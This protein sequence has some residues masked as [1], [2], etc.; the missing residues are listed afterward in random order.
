MPIIQ[1]NQSF[2]DIFG[3][4]TSFLK[5][6]AGDLQTARISIRESIS[7]NSALGESIQNNFTLDLMTWL[8]G[9]WEAEG[10]RVGDSIGIITYI[11][12][13]G[14]VLASTTTNVVYINGDEME[15]GLALSSW[16]DESSGEAVIIFNN[17]NREQMTLDFNMVVNG[18]AGSQY[19]LIDGEVS[20]FTFDL[21]GGAGATGVQIGNKSGAYDVSAQML[22]NSTSGIFKNYDLVINFQQSGL[23]D[24]NLFSFDNCLKLYAKMSWSS[25][26]GEPFGQTESIFNDDADTGWF[27]E[28]FNT[29]SIDATLVQGISE[30]GYD[31]PTSGQF[32]I[33]SASNDYAIGSAYISNDDSYFKIQPESQ[34]NLTMIVPSSIPISGVANQS[35]LNPD[36][37]GYTIEL[38]NIATAGTIRT[39]DFTFTPNSAFTTFMEAQTEGNRSFYVWMK[40]GSVNVL[41]FSGQLT[42]QPVSAGPITMV[43]S[44]FFDHSQQLTDGS[45]VQSGYAGNVEDDF[46]WIGKWRWIKKAVVSYVRVGVQAYN[47]STGASFTLQQNNFSLNNIPQETSGLEAYILD[48]TQ[49]VN[50][51]LPTTSVKREIRLKRDTSLDQ[52]TQYG[53]SL[54]FPYLYRW[55]YWLQLMNVSPDFYPDEQTRN[56][57]PYGNTGN[58]TLRLFVEYDMNGLAYKYYDTLQIKDY[59][60]DANIQQDIQLFRA[61]PL[62]NVQVIIEGEQMKIVATNTNLNGDAWEEE[63]TWGMITIEPTE[64]SPRWI[65]STAIDFDGNTLNPLTPLSGLRCDLTFPS[66]DVARLECNFD[67]SKID[68]SAGVK[69]TA[70]IKGCHWI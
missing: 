70:K 55:E 32:V 69:I 39:I 25:L 45:L 54:Y 33:D 26:L 8:G 41:V 23:Y 9:D 63:T 15:V 61:D 66:P 19:S 47:T 38:T 14:I 27:N 13:S 4:N 52:V 22:L 35:A 46:G 62:Q 18:S 5:G 7:V 40:F 21:S 36:G 3:N 37:A 49:A 1:I 34:S 30:L 48:E 42:K 28:A 57:V 59:D 58:W 6:N 65:S 24:S 29:G 60:S 31:Q 17:R 11:Q 51:T 16:Y 20:R 64:S 53:V 44:E 43:V 67:P 10:F 50:S 12:S 56:W 68:L 2:Q